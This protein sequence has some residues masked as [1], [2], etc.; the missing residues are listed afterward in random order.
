MGDD[1]R[2]SWDEIWMNVA[3]DVARR[4][5]CSRAQVGCV[6]VSASNNVLAA[7][8]NGPPAGADTPGTCIDWCPRAQ[9]AARG[10][11]VDMD[12]ATCVSS[13]AESNSLARMDSSQA[14]GG[15]LYVSSAMCRT[16][17]PAVA[18]TGV[19]RVVMMVDEKHAYRAPQAV[20]DYLGWAGIEVMVVRSDGC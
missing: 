20:I 9:A 13:H 12:Y 1:A 16:C 7:S 17:A 5:K 11:T 18:N 6:V 2:P 4:S 14:L 10:E 19:R 3:K 15:T 8:Y